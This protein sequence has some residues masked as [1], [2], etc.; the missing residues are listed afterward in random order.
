MVKSLV[1]Q[2]AEGHDADV[3]QAFQAQKQ[4][5]VQQGCCVVEGEMV[6]GINAIAAP[7]F[8]ANNDVVFVLLAIAVLLPLLKLPLLFFSTD[9]QLFWQFGM[10]SQPSASDRAAHIELLQRHL[11]D[12]ALQGKESTR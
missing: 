12:A 9:D 4:R 2:A 6:L 3:W 1:A 10:W 11:Q 7:V 8:D 5:I